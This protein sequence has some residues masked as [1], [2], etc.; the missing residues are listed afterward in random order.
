MKNWNSY[1]KTINFLNLLEKNT[2]RYKLP[3]KPKLKVIE[4]EM[5][6]GIITETNN[7]FS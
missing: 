1:E 2:K 6:I 4:D 3:C 5:V 7:L